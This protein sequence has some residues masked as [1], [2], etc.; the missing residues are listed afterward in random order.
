MSK[1][2]KENGL[3]CGAVVGR[4]GRGLGE[5]QGGVL[6]F[7]HSVTGSSHLTQQ[8]VLWDMSDTA[9]IPI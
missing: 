7:I 8:N 6:S 3:G 4:R 1:E 2:G 9:D 5:I